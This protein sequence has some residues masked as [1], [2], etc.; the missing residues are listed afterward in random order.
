[1]SSPATLLMCTAGAPIDKTC[2]TPEGN[3]SGTELST[4]SAASIVGGDQDG[5]RV[6]S[7]VGLERKRCKWSLGPKSPDPG[8]CAQLMAHTVHEKIAWAALVARDLRLAKVGRSNL[9]G[10]CHLTYQ[11]PRAARRLLPRPSVSRH[12][13]KSG[14]S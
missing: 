13:S 7:V 10:G 11:A 2:R 5:E 1:M 8:C 6:E 9:P 4:R 14:R 3:R 12:R